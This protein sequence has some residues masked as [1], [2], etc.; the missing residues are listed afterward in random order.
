MSYY[1]SEC[2]FQSRVCEESLAE[3]LLAGF[4][5]SILSL[6]TSMRRVKVG[7]RQRTEGTRLV[8]VSRHSVTPQLLCRRWSGPLK[9]DRVHNPA[10][11]W[12]ATG[13]DT[14]PV[15]YPSGVWVQ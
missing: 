7:Y 15:I 11:V 6:Q 4:D 8:P 5:S 1:I 10:L 2:V 14:G 3:R 12:T 13:L 9:H